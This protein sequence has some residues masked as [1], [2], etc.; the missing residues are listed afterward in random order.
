M[1]TPARCLVLAMF[2]AFISCEKHSLMDISTIDKGQFPAESI[3]GVSEENL[4]SGYSTVYFPTFSANWANDENNSSLGCNSYIYYEVRNSSGQLI[5]SRMN[6]VGGSGNNH[7][8]G[9]SRSLPSGN[10]TITFKNISTQT[11]FVPINLIY[12]ASN[13]SNTN[14]AGGM[15]YHKPLKPGNEVTFNMSVGSA[16][17]YKMNCNTHWVKNNGDFTPVFPSNEMAIPSSYCAAF[18]PSAQSGNLVWNNDDGDSGTNPATLPNTQSISLT[19]D[20]VNYYSVANPFYNGGGTPSNVLLSTSLSS[21][22]QDPN[23]GN[24]F[25][26]ISFSPS[27]G[28]GSYSRFGFKYQGQSNNNI[29]WANWT[30]NSQ[31]YFNLLPGGYTF[32]IEDSNGNIASSNQSFSCSGCSGSAAIGLSI[33][34]STCLQDPNNGNCFKKISFNPSGGSG[35]YTRFGFKYQGQSNSNI[36]WANWT[37]SSQSYFNLLSGAYT[38][39]IEDTSGNIAS[40]DQVYSCSSCN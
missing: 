33:S 34:L 11:N 39:Y 15:I 28:S 9:A 23:N 24:C 38:F 5:L 13:S 12:F 31:S 25:K 10:Y 14:A 36:Y 26:K 8:S 16:P 35:S 19:E 20:G 6:V 18:Q 37:N 40:S 30:N 3:D 4:I 17:W 2:L 27:G 32:Y 21:C 1:K 7:P 22:L 29:Y